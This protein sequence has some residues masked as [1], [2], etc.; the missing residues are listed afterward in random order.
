MPP[1]PEVPPLPELPH[2][3]SHVPPKK[4]QEEPHREHSSSNRSGTHFFVPLANSLHSVK[5]SQSAFDSHRS[6]H[7]SGASQVVA[8]VVGFVEQSGCMPPQASQESG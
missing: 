3:T 7:A 6:P 2:S 8:H 4:L 1:V 5:A